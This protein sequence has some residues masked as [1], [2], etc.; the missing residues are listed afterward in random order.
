M[1]RETTHVDLI[2]VVIEAVVTLSV[3]AALAFQKYRFNNG[4]ILGATL[5]AVDWYEDTTRRK[6]LPPSRL[7][8]L[9]IATS[10]AALGLAL[11]QVAR[12][13]VTG[14]PQSITHS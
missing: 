2:S 7:T 10:A 14:L 1:L 4:L 9:L 3:Q 12:V 6:G 5:A 13:F 8:V 11:Q